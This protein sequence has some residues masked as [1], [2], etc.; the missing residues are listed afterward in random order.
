MPKANYKPKNAYQRMALQ[1]QAQPT[2]PS[3]SPT[4]WLQPGGISHAH[5]PAI[6]TDTTTKEDRYAPR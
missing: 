6:P 2:P 1:A 5:R 4:P 3:T